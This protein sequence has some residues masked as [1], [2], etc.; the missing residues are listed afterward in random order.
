MFYHSKKLSIILM[1]FLI[2]YSTLYEL[3]KIFGGFDK[4]RWTEKVGL[5]YFQ[6]MEFVFVVFLLII[7]DDITHKSNC[8]YFRMS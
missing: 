5:P 6:N 2:F 4:E 3:Q 8:I 1:T 7:L